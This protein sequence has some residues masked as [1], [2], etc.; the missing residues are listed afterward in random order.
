ML[1]ALSNSLDSNWDTVWWVIGGVLTAGLLLTV[2]IAIWQRSLR[3]GIWGSVGILVMCSLLAMMWHY[4]G[5]ETVHTDT[6]WSIRRHRVLG[7][8]TLLAYDTDGDGF[9]DAKYVYRLSGPWVPERDDLHYYSLGKEDRNYDGRW[10]T[11]LRPTNQT[12]DGDT[13]LLFQADTDL[14]GR[15]DF[16]TLKAASVSSEAY[17]EV[18]KQRGF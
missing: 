8:I 7:R 2:I 4:F 3:I 17:E 10:D 11:W 12:E 15:P 14:D 18:E 13:V 16:E 1:L 5:W 9:A 6:G